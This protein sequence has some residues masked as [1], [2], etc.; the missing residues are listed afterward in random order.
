[1]NPGGA[2]PWRVL[3]FAP[4]GVSDGIGDFSERLASA[5]GAHHPAG[6]FVRRATWRELDAVD[7]AT[8]GGVVI[9][10]FPQAYLHGDFRY[11]VRWLERAR[12]AGVPI[13]TTVHEFWPPADGTF[14]RAAAR[15]LF[16]RLLRTLVRASDHVVVTRPSALHDLAEAV[17]T[18][19]AVVIPVGTSVLPPGERP[20]FPDEPVAKLPPTK[21]V[22]FGQPA[23]MDGAV[24]AAVSRWV[25]ATPGASLEWVARSAG[26]MQDAWRRFGA[27]PGA[28]VTFSAGVP[29]DDLSRRFSAATIGLAPNVNGTSTRRGTFV[30]L[31]GH[32]LPIVATSGPNTGEALV[33]AAPCVFS[34]E[35]E[36]APFVDRLAA[37]AAD[38]ERQAAL[39]R[40]AREY[41]DRTLAW[42]HIADAYAT[43]LKR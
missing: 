21:L 25:A 41:Y 39:G 11:L 23:A 3:T 7:P 15:W 8:L 18:D 12:A 40:A 10:Y 22:M 27:D 6:T 36:P 42:R 37:L 17:R 29:A 26:E 20:A 34:P 16:R 14:R 2:R 43:L 30:A 38:P 24:L 19:R 13:V 28:R 32:G 33:E 35:G 31:L 4:A 9:Q 1:M 5:L